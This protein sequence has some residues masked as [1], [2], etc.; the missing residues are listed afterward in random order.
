[1]AAVA[2][3]EAHSR[4]GRLLAD[5]I[6]RTHGQRAHIERVNSMGKLIVAHGPDELEWD[7]AEILLV[8]SD[9]QLPTVIT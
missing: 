3:L 1:M 7:N 8:E 2:L 5:Y 6:G 9:D 4:R